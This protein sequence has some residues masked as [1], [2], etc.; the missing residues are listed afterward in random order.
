MHTNNKESV[1]QYEILRQEEKGIRSK[2]SCKC[3]DNATMHSLT[4][5]EDVMS[6]QFNTTPRMNTHTPTQCVCVHIERERKNNFLSSYLCFVFVRL[7]YGCAA[8][9]SFMVSYNLLPIFVI[10]PFPF[11]IFPSAHNHSTIRT[12]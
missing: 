10:F 11:Y 9:L 4:E 7:L 3:I 8:R 1:K 2:L 6:A 12:A 5:N